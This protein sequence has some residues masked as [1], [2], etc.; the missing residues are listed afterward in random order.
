[1]RQKKKYPELTWVN[2][3]FAKII[4]LRYLRIIR[5]AVKLEALASHMMNIVTCS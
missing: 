4:N 2:I 1:M 5:E 3:F